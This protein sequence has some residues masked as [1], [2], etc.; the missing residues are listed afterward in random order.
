MK[1]IFILTTFLFSIFCL[2]GQTW[3]TI[4]AGV[5]DFLL[6]NP[7]TADQMKSEHQAALGIIGNLLNTAGQRK[8]E[9]NVAEAGRT[10]MNFHTNSGQQI[11]L[12]MDA[13]GSVYAL[14][15]GVIYPISQN[16]VNEAREYV[17]N[18][19][20]GYM[21]YVKSN[22]FHDNTQLMLPDFNIEQLKNN[23]DQKLQSKL[24]PLYYKRPLYFSEILDDWDA[25]IDEIYV[26]NVSDEWVRINKSGLY[27]KY[28]SNDKIVG[29]LEGRPNVHQGA[30][31][32]RYLYLNKTIHHERGAFTAKWHHDMNNNS[33]LEFN[34]FQDIRRNFYENEPFLIAAGIHSQYNCILKLTIFEQLSGK[35]VLK[36]DMDAVCGYRKFGSNDFK[37]G[38][39]NYHISFIRIKTNEE[40][41][42][43]SDRFQVLPLN[44]SIS[45]E[46]TENSLKNQNNTDEA[47]KEKMINDL[48]QLLKDG[49]ISE[50]TFKASMK[51]LENK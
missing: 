22:K 8:H 18:Q 41:A 29:I 5:A 13:N 6:S 37:A 38:I 30:R 46:K 20:P 1:K 47:S 10:Q 42:N 36:D 40:I 17:L 48:I 44:E 3:E 15:N 50:E 7:K 11:Q 35:I 39:Y 32:G 19:Q 2:Q 49:K 45:S 28:I 34:E 27:N 25:I 4:G 33:S 43:F 9:I 23:W 16:V 24:I 21:D 14:S 31:R 51:A 26:T 12:V